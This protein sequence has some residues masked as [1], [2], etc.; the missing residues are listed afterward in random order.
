MVIDRG[1]EN[2]DVV[3]ELVKRYKVKKLV[4][5]IYHPQTNGMIERGH[6]L[7]VDTLSKMLARESTYLFRNLPAILWAD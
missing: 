6:K 5:S 2:K 7:I 3:A 1:S 4:V